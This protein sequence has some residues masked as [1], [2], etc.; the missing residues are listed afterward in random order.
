MRRSWRVLTKSMFKSCLKQTSARHPYSASDDGSRL[1]NLAHRCLRKQPPRSTAGGRIPGHQL[2]RRRPG[3]VRW[4]CLGA[5]FRAPAISSSSNSSHSR[6][7]RC[8]SGK[9]QREHR[10]SRQ[11]CSGQRRGGPP[12]SVQSP[13]RCM[14]WNITHNARHAQYHREAMH[15][16]KKHSQ[17]TA[18]I[19]EMTSV[20]SL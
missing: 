6:R 8:A 4:G 12:P 3:L 14:L 15:A 5:A 2:R 10:R 17:D 7:M 9:Q 1:C 11:R 20:P 13:T 18:V 16:L 19:H